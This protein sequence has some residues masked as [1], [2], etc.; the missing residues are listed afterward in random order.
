MLISSPFNRF[1]HGVV[2]KQIR[3]IN[4]P[5]IISGFKV[6]FSSISLQSTKKLLKHLDYEYPRDENYE[7]ISITKIDNKGLCKHIE[8]LI[9]SLGLNGKSFAFVEEEWERLMK[10]YRLE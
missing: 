1:L 5:L 10:E 6:R 9:Y 7:P 2:Y 4:E 3:Q 8:W